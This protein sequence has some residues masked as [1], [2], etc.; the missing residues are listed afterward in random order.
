M[1]CLRVFVAAVL[2][3]VPLVG[4]GAVAP[5]VRCVPD[6]QVLPCKP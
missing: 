5:I 1:K 6:S 2:V 4:C 3:A